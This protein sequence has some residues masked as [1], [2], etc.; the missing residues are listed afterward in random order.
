MQGYNVVFPNGYDTFGLPAENAAIKN[1]MHHKKWTYENI[2]VMRE[3]FERM[4]TMIDWTKSV[5]TCEPEYYKWNQ[6]IFLKML[7]RGIAYHGETISN[8]CPTCQTVLADEN[9]EAGR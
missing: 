4:G 8:W 5:I 7:E 1:K 6:W 9:V 2:K 3:Q